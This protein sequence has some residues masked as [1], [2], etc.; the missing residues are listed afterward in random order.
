M[1]PALG[2][3]DAGGAIKA[4]LVCDPWTGAAWAVS[5]GRRL[6]VCD[7]PGCAL[8]SRKLAWPTATLC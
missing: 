6:V 8:S 5:H 4:T 1:A 7:P 2:R 3:C